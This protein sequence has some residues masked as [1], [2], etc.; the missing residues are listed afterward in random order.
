MVEMTRE[1]LEEIIGQVAMGEYEAAPDWDKPKIEEWAAGLSALSD[2]DFVLECSSK[3]YDSALL[4]RFRG[5]HEGTHCRATACYTE[6]ERRHRE[7][8]HAEDCRGSSLYSEGHNLALRTAG[9]ATSEPYPCTCGK[10]DE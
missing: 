5:N 1:Q 7:A 8:G 3:I 4:Q 6:A 9:H 2:K 10:G